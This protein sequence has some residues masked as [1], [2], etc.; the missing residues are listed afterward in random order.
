M[1]H[2]LLHL[3]SPT[4]GDGFLHFAPSKILR[5][6][7]DALISRW[8]GDPHRPCLGTTLS[9]L[10]VLI[11]STVRIDCELLRSRCFSSQIQKSKVRG[12]LTGDHPSSLMQLCTWRSF[13][14][15]A[16]TTKTHTGAGYCSL[17]VS[18][19]ARSLPTFLTCRRSGISFS[20]VSPTRHLSLLAA[21]HHQQSGKSTWRVL[22]MLYPYLS[23]NY[24]FQI[25][26]SSLSF[27]LFDFSP[28]QPA[29]IS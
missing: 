20:V 1:I 26:G 11:R 28:L 22:R 9:R 19:Y 21:G 25:S 23:F 12:S 5:F 18:A 6:Q 4:A 17:L 3:P 15:D 27:S 10:G 2:D 7:V 13:I 16:T 29:T 8:W 24:V 14:P